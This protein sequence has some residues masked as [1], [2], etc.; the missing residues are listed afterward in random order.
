MRNS[1]KIVLYTITD[2][3]NHRSV[4]VALAVC[5]LFV[6]MLRG[7][8]RGPITVNGQAIDP[9]TIAWYASKVAFHLITGGAL[10]I[11]SLLSM[12]LLGRDRDDGTSVMLLSRPVRRA[13]YLVGRIGGL[14]IVSSLFMLLLHLTVV[15]ISFFKVGSTMPAYMPASLIC[16]LNVLFLVLLVCLL[17]LLMPEFLAAATGLLV[18]AISYISESSFQIMQSNLLKSALGTDTEVPVSLWRIL[19]PKIA[20]VNYYA[21]SLTGNEPYQYMGPLPP[22]I[23]IVFYTALLI[24]L[25]LWRFQHEEL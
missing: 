9:A 23:N 19:F 12:R 18:T 6:L 4:Y 20:G 15:A 16:C 17:S 2:I 11:A 22:V 14:W 10:M 3:M 7:C 13:E 1:K 21:S 24:G 5:V 25:L 8:F